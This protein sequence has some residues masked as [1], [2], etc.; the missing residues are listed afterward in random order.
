M[1]AVARPD[2]LVARMTG[3]SWCWL[4]AEEWAADQASFAA[5]HHKPFPFTQVNDLTFTNLTSSRKA[6][7]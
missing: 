6:L 2:G 1:F 3:E 4:T 5:A 7:R